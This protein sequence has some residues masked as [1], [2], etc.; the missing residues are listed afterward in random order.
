MT[1]KLSKDD[2]RM[3]IEQHIMRILAPGAVNSASVDVA[4]LYISSVDVEV[5]FPGDSRVPIKALVSS[6]EKD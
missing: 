5:Q 4:D 6:A 3:A 2:I 1:I